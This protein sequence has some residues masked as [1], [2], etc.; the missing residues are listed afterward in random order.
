MAKKYK[1]KFTKYEVMVVR[2]ILERIGY[3]DAP[4]LSALKKLKKIKVKDPEKPK[5]KDLMAVLGHYVTEEDR[6][7]SKDEFL[8]QVIDRIDEDL[9]L[10]KE[11][12]IKVPN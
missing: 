4:A 5:R 11:G 2:D 9:A 7:V 3:Q 10:R 1:V 8:R 12:K 6:D